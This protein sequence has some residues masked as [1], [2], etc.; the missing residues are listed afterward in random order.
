MNPPSHPSPASHRLRSRSR[1][2]ANATTVTLMSH[3]PGLGPGS[4]ATPPVAS[5]PS[6][7]EARSPRPEQNGLLSSLVN[8]LGFLV[9]GLQVPTDGADEVLTPSMS[10]D[11]H[12]EPA[13]YVGADGPAEAM[14]PSTADYDPQVILIT[15][16]AGFIG[17]NMVGYLAR[18]YEGTG[19][20]VICL[21]RMDYCA[22]PYS[23]RELQGLQC[24]KIIQAC[25]TDLPLMRKIIEEERVDTVIHF[26]AQSHVDNSFE[27]SL[28]FTRDNVIGTH[29]LLE[30][31]RL[32]PAGQMRRFIH[33][34]TDEVY[35]PAPLG[36]AFK[37][38]DPMAPTNPYAA[39]KGRVR[40]QE[41]GI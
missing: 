39:T 30:A 28:S 4:P 24:L 17:S 22:C 12:L 34:S 35:G 36:Q 27:S 23:L 40:E 33:V 16:G 5:S 2:G 11:L 31:S 38:T 21:D 7:A 14:G 29:A 10:M 26:A 1:I 6:P 13:L 20:R 37:E 18:K 15:G 32:A 3:A 8:R 19:R 25:I 9:Q 41:R